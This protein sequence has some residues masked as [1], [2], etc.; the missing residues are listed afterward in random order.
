MTT[1]SDLGYLCYDAYIQAGR[2]P[3]EI[4]E[5]DVGAWVRVC[6]WRAARRGAPGTPGKP[7]E[8]KRVFI[9]Q[10]LT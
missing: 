2:T 6:A 1:L 8:K 10:V 5:I 7:P 9:D 4:D 3:A